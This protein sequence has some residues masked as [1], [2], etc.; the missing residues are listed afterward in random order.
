MD[1]ATFAWTK[2]Q[3]PRLR[4]DLIARGELEERLREALLARPLVLLVAAAGYGKTAL[5]AQTLRPMAASCAL[6][7][8]SADE[9]DDLQRFLAC[10]SGALEPYDLP[11]RVAPEALADIAQQP[12]GLQQVA[13][14]L[15]AALEGSDVAHGVIAIDDLHCVAEPR[16]LELLQWLLKGLPR[17]WTLAIASRIDPPWSLARLRVQGDLAEFR[18]ADLRFS[19]REVQRLR[20]LQ[21]VE[22]RGTVADDLLERVDG[23]AAGV[24]LVL[25]SSGSGAAMEPGRR[26]GQRHLFDYLAHEVFEELPPS[27]R[28]F[29]MRCSVLS[30]LTTGRCAEVSGEPRAAELLEDLERRGLFVSVLDAEELTLRLHDLFR[31][32]LEDRLLRERAHELP[33][34]LR[35]AAVSEPDPVRRVSYLLRAAAWP[36]AEQ[37]LLEATPQMLQAGVGAQVA[38]LVEQF[39]AEQREQSPALAYALGLCAWPA[40]QGS[41]VQRKMAS[42]AAG[43]EQRGQSVLAS[44]ALATEAVALVCLN[45]FDEAAES[46][47]RLDERNTGDIE[48]LAMRRHAAY[49]LAGIR[50]PAH[51]VAPALDAL[52]D[53]LAASASPD[54]V[55]RCY[56]LFYFFGRPG[57]CAA[58]ERC[59]HLGLKVAGESHWHLRAAAQLGQAFVHI[60]RGQVAA[61]AA[62]LRDLQQDHRWHGQLSTLLLRIATGLA[63]CATIAGDRPGCYEA[64]RAMQVGIRSERAKRLRRPYGLYI[65]RL[66]GAWE[67]WP[68]VRAALAEVDHASPED[69]WPIDAIH[70]QVM[71]ASLLLNEDRVAEALAL[72]RDAVRTA[73][74]IDCMNVDEF[75]RLTLAR[76]E[77]RAGA[78]EAA[79]QAFAPV[80]RRARI[81]HEIGGLLQLGP[82]PL[83]ELA[84]A[85]W[86]TRLD[87]AD[88]ALLEQM[89]G[90]VRQAHRRPVPD[91]AAA[92]RREA[93]LTEREIEVVSRI[94]LGKSNKIIARE[95]DLSPH[96]VKRHVARI[97]SKLDVTSRARAG[98]WYL[99]QSISTQAGR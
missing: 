6:A 30:E 80:L 2:T 34:L 67:D 26:L 85:S 50:G 49:C 58:V 64:L 68:A 76:A 39:P 51:A 53:V 65:A 5:L 37:V 95:L 32:F 71:E 23:W 13:E 59:A 44:R 66:Y 72:S 60:M 24:N 14:L 9:D 75:A 57:A 19:A 55:S 33:E 10:L 74:D 94:A 35:R 18:E 12:H 21:P 48:T 8:I 97:L 69:A 86:G 61:A 46:L 93:L 87:A 73:A 43:F 16:V 7:W 63:I 36:E 77:L 98:N 20:Q 40:L 42:A 22:W 47:A 25:R 91:A 90:L 1:I 45:R 52:V 29:L 27:L 38:R 88:R 89:A 92:P 15:N 54:I 31:D 17:K 11:W 3:P 82:A 83:E 56:P 79:Q 84:G 28:D 41:V 99:E 62:L 81:E 78:P 70:R 96:T 4:S